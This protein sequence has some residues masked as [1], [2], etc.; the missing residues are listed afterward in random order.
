MRLAL[1]ELRS[2]EIHSTPPIKSPDP[3]PMQIGSSQT[4]QIQID[5]RSN[6]PVLTILDS[7]E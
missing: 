4:R 6:A 5:H 2:L 1:Q 7:A 3:Q